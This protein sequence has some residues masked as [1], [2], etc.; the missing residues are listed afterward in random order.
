MY[1]KLPIYVCSIAKNEAAH[2]RRWAESA[3][4]ADGIYMLD[5]GSDDDTVAIA[6]ECGVIVFEKTYERWSFAAARN[7]HKNSA[8]VLAFNFVRFQW[9]MARI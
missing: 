6:R 2:V 8:A 9:C 7:A 1:D 3:K 4:D 5:T